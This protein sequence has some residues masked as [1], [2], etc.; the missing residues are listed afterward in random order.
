MGN[1][2][3][4]VI[5]EDEKVRSEIVQ[6]E[7]TLISAKTQSFLYGRGDSSEF[8]SLGSISISF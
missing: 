1:L 5:N 7:N 6:N 8:R 3:R 2:T 4:E